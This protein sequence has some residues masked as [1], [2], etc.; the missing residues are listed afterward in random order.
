VRVAGS[1]TM[2]NCTITEWTGAAVVSVGSGT[3]TICNTICWLNGEQGN[4][5]ATDDIIGATDFLVS[6]SII[7]QTIDSSWTSCWMTDP[8]FID[9]DLRP[10]VCSIANGNASEE[11]LPLDDLDVNFNMNT[12]EQL[13]LD[14]PKFDGDPECT[15]HLIP[16]ALARKQGPLDIGAREIESGTRSVDWNND[17]VIDFFDYLDFVADSSN[18]DADFNGDTV[19]DLFD[20]LDF[21]G[22]FSTC[23]T[24]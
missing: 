1:L 12:T 7:Q 8:L 19:T 3:G 17:G 9:D 21:V 11:C 14:C 4:E 15:N 13:P 5:T 20:Y 23:Y 24:P 2:T 6:H 16:R 10:S 22:Q 18:N